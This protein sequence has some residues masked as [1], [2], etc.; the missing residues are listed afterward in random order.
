MVLLRADR[1]QAAVADGRI[2][3]EEVD[4]YVSAA[5]AFR[6]L[7]NRSGPTA[8]LQ[9]TERYRRARAIICA[10]AFGHGD[11]QLDDADAPPE[12]AVAG[13]STEPY[14]AISPVGS[15]KTAKKPAVARRARCWQSR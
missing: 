8:R 3:Q 1:L 14:E 15:E 9:A 5:R 10:K 11:Y 13:S 6:Q 2:T 12:R 7:T 4:G